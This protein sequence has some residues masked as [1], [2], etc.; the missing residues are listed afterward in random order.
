MTRNAT[1]SVLRRSRPP[2]LAVALALLAVAFLVVP[3]VGLLTEASWSSLWHDLRTPVAAQALRLSLVCSLSATALALALGLPLAWVLARTWLPGRRAVRTLATLPMVM[4]PVVAGVAL[5][6]AFGRHGLLGRP[7]FDAFGV[8]FTFR[9]AGVVL[10]EAFVAMPFLV[11]TVEAALRGLDRRYEEASATLGA[12]RWTTFRRVTL[13][14]IAPSVVAGTA[15]TWAR[16]LGEFGA[17]LTF[18]GNIQ[19]RTQTLP[20]AIE[21]ALQDDEPVAVALSLALLAVSMAVLVVL[22]GRWLG[23]LGMAGR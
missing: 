4:P 7:L 13:P 15:L 16:A 19:G 20:L 22:R 18:A 17:T 21:L 12:G 2:A 3:L 10:A 11:L 5:L 1:R 6:G 9:T 14:L 23:A 8:Q